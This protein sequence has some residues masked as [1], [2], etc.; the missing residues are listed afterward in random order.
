MKVF[1]SIP[2]DDIGKIPEA[3]RRA[4]ELGYDGIN[5]N[6]N[7][8]SPF[9]ALT[10]A[11][12]HTSRALLGTSVAIVF[13]ISPM[14]T[15]YMAWELH[16]FSGGRFQLG[17]GSQVKGHIERRFSTA[18]TPPGP[19]MKE[20]VLSLRAIW[21]SFQNGA[22]LRFEG[23][24][25]NF[26]L[27]TPHFNPGPLETP[28]PKILI[29][30]V[31]PYMFRLAGEVCDGVLPHGFMTPKYMDEVALPNLER[32]L[33]R[34]G[35]TLKDI[36]IGAGGFMVTG[37]NEEEVG[38]AFEEVRGRIAFYGSTRTYKPVMDV[39]GWGDVC[40]EL[41]R[42]QAAGQWDAMPSII[43][44]EMVEAF[45]T[46]GTHDQIV[47]KIRARY[48]SYA[49]QIGFSMPLQRPGDEE[50]LRDKIKEIQAIAS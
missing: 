9:M 14:T 7:F 48:S 12:E 38:R 33:K 43:T 1:G 24:H 30:A 13:P 40:L 8:S 45:A 10:L 37:E 39:H 4:E 20:Y 23:E 49:T 28:P 36:E 50:R 6:E 11:A 47:D 34:S 35:R 42:M 3:A 5:T 31:G 16:K 27:I 44:D 15:A 18:W 21:D 32:G 25:Y 46:I 17:M 29:S 22:P 2:R 26:S 41:N 19:R